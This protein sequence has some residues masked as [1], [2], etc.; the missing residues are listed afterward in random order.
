MGSL[1]CCVTFFVASIDRGQFLFA[2]VG[3]VVVIVILKMRSQDVS[4]LAFRW[5]DS[6]ESGKA[7]GYV[8]ALGVA[9][10]WFWHSRYR[11]RLVNQEMHR[12]G[13]L[14]NELQ[15]KLLGKKLKSS[16]ERP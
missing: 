7:L 10:G 9:A 16:G 15:S 8:L 3:F 12:L 11:Q 1:K 13:Q 14:R 5:L 2:I 4:K 6:I